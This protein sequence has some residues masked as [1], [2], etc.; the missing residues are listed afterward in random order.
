[1]LLPYNTEANKTFR[2]SKNIISLTNE[3]DLLNKQIKELENI[4]LA[5]EAQ[6]ILETNTR[7][8]AIFRDVIREFPLFF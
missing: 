6:L 1:M 8:R 2:N 3:I 5:K 7:N 4:K